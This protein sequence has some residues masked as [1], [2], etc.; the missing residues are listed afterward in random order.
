LDIVA[1]DCSCAPDTLQLSVDNSQV[2][3][4]TCGATGGRSIEVSPGTHVVSAQSPKASWPP[5]SVAASAGTK[6]PV[7]LGCPAK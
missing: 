2:G 3:A 5:R 1:S 6:T 7:E 4:I